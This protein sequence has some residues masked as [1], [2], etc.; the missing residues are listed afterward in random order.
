VTEEGVVKIIDLG[1][2]RLYTTQS[3]GY[4]TTVYPTFRF[5]APELIEEEDDI[6]YMSVT[7][8]TDVYAFSMTALQVCDLGCRFSKRLK[9]IVYQVLDGQGARSLPFNNL[10]VDFDVRLAVLKGQWP[11]SHR[12]GGVPLGAWDLLSCCWTDPSSRPSIDALLK[13]LSAY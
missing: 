11:E 3:A 4:T 8:P 5:I 1:L 6:V 9:N 2:S 12:Y 13:A 7:K 10:K